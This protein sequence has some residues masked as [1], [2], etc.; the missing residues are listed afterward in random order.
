MADLR[1][2]LGVFFILL[3]AALFFLFFDFKESS[4]NYILLLFG[5]ISAFITYRIF[6]SIPK[7]EPQESQRFRTMRKL[8]GS[9]KNRKERR[10]SRKKNG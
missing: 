7:S 4:P 10:S 9:R 3:T 1:R 8:K 2:R 6:K 5:V